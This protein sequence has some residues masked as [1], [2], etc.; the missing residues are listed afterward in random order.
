MIHPLHVT[1]IIQDIQKMID[2]SLRLYG[3]DRIGSFDYVLENA[4]GSVMLDYCSRTYSQ[5]TAT[6]RLFGFILWYIT[7]SP[8]VIIQVSE[9]VWCAGMVVERRGERGG[10]SWWWRGERGRFVEIYFIHHV[11]GYYMW[12]LI[13]CQYENIIWMFFCKK[14]SFYSLFFFSFLFLFN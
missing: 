5:S 10:V 1:I 11:D 6:I 12:G 2:F 14:R 13:C 7:S 8:K 9:C 3:A 4:G